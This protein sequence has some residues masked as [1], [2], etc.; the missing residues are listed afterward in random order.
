[1]RGQF[2]R[3]LAGCRR[4]KKLTVRK[5][6]EKIEYSPS[7][8]SE[9]ETGRRLPPKNHEILR[10]LA[11]I[12]EID[13]D[14]FIKS[15]EK[16]RME[17]DNFLFRKLKPDLAWLFYR[18]INDADQDSLEEAVRNVISDLKNKKHKGE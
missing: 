8:L 16:E 4:E 5:L 1:M 13:A 3:W 7:Q 2:G 15:A 12:L 14:E 6:A 10:K 17:K 11:S 18:E 9:I